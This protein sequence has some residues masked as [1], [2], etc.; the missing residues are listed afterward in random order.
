M[1]SPLGRGFVY[2]TGPGGLAGEHPRLKVADGAVIVRVEADG[3]WTV[4]AGV[5]GICVEDAYGAD[6]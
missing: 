1:A 3:A 5:D 2:A 4:R 6:R